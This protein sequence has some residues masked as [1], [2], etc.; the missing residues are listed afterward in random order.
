MIARKAESDRGTG[1]EYRLGY[2]HPHLHRHRHSFHADSVPT[3]GLRSVATSN[4]VHQLVFS[5]CAD[6]LNNCR[7]NQPHK[8]EGDQPPHAVAQFNAEP[9]KD[10]EASQPR[11]TVRPASQ[12]GV[13]VALSQEQLQ[14]QIE[15][16][17]A[18]TRESRS[19]RPAGLGRRIAVHFLS[20]SPPRT[21]YQNRQSPSFEP[22]LG[23][24]LN[25]RRNAR[26]RYLSLM[27]WL[28]TIREPLRDGDI[29]LSFSQSLET[30]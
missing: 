20:Y 3:P 2:H 13:V 12:K 27:A 8:N 28:R 25:G 19:T 6:E 16:T 22:S 4:K 29:L 15:E 30:S 11:S 17:P 10:V 23:G 7:S 9:Y 5:T 24:A 26:G 14:V 21:V 1:Q 18:T